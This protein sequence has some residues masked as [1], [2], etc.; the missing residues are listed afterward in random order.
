LSPFAT[1]TTTLSHLLVDANN[2]S[3]LKWKL[4]G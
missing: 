2:S 4:V 1:W 3:N